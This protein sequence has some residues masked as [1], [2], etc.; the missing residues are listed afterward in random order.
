MRGQHRYCADFMAREEE[1]RWSLSYERKRMKLERGEIGRRW[2]E[3]SQL[4]RGR[5]RNKLHGSSDVMQLYIT[6][7]GTSTKIT[8]SRFASSTACFLPIVAPGALNGFQI[9]ASQALCACKAWSINLSLRAY[10]PAVC[11]ICDAF[12]RWRLSRLDGEQSTHAMG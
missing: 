12:Y 3:R 2:P 1:S 7:A 9:A 5:S 6:A 11:S 4:P 8:C 10:T